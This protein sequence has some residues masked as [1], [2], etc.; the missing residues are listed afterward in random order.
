[1]VRLVP[2]DQLLSDRVAHEL[3]PRKAALLRDVL[4]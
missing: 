3:A 1:V 2:R 4:R